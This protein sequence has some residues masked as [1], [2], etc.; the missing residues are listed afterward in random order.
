[1]GE[2]EEIGGYL[3]KVWNGYCSVH[4]LFFFIISF[5]ILYESLIFLF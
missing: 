3:M 4:S 2:M 1:M 5:V